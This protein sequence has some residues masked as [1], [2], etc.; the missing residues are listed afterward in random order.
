MNRALW[1]KA[2][3]G[4]WLQ[5]LVCSVLLVLFGAVFVWLMSFFD[6]GVWGKFLEVLPGFSR[7]IMGLPIGKLA[8]PLGQISVAFVHVVTILT[9]M[10]WAVGRG[11]DP[12]SGEIGRGTMDLTLTLPVRRASVLLVPAVIT[13]AGAFVL[14]AALLVGLW[15]GLTATGVGKELSICAFLPG[16]WNLVGLM[17]AVSGLTAL[18]SAFNRSRWR[19]ISITAGFYIFSFILWIVSRLWESGGWLKYTCFLTAYDPQRLILVPEETWPLSIRYNAT[20]VILGV[21]AYAAASFV[22]SRRDIPAA[23]Q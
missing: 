19:A 16:A 10:G 5:L 22:F 7:R 18:I 6:M 3:A 21:L 12:I 11:S 20:L 1:K 23:L 2:L 17:F 9:C 4:A 14:A 8:T 15:I 13:T